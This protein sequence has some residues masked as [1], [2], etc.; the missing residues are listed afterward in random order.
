MLWGYTSMQ[1]CVGG[2]GGVSKQYSVADEI[3]IVCVADK[4][5]VVLSLSQLLSFDAFVRA[6]VLKR[7][8]AT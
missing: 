1:R 4:R 3:E 6:A 5:L 8:S 2:G 7:P